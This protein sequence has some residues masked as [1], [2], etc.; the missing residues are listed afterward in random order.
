MAAT[1]DPNSG[2]DIEN[3]PRISPVAILGRKPLLLFRGAVLPD[4]NRRR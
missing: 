3:A 2:S 1:S 4:R